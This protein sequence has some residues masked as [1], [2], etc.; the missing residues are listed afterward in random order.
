MK[1]TMSPK[2][3]WPTILNGQL[4]DCQD[5]WW[6][7]ER[8][9]NT[10]SC[11]PSTG[12]WWWSPRLASC[13]TSLRMHQSTSVIAWRTCWSTAT[14]SMTS[15]TSRTIPQCRRSCWGARSWQAQR[16][17]VP[18]SLRIGSSF[19]GWMC[20]ETPAGRCASGTKR[21]EER[22]KSSNCVFSGD[23]RGRSLLWNPPQCE[24][25]RAGVC[26]LVYTCCYAGDTG[27]RCTGHLL[28]NTDSSLPSHVV[29]QGATNIFTSV[30]SMD[31]KISQIDSK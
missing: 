22:F 11:R 6:G 30:H 23:P 20:Q 8:V 10:S 9:W 12:F 29:F 5:L 13:S 14:A 21:C 27:V 17:W 2:K 31:L 26:G 4:G 19:V 15:S 3:Q 28:P 18:V 1:R 24:S 7:P 16:K 25:Q